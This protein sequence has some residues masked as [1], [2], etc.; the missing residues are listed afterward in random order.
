MKQRKPFT[1]HNSRGQSL[2]ETALIL[3]LL[4][5]LVL[6]VVNLAY[7]LLTVVNLTAAARTSVL[8]AIE[9]GATPAAGALP[10]AGGTA[11]T[12]N[13]GSVTYLA[14]QDL[15]GALSNP[16]GVTVQVC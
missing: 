8:Y 16:T 10:S 4:V 5:M 7:F 2:V 13:T 12:T 3:P 14:Y 1:T 15:T 9:G 11:P 6:N